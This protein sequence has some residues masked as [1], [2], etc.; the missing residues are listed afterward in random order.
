[1]FTDAD[2]EAVFKVNKMVG[3]FIY[4]NNIYGTKS[5]FCVKPDDVADI[6]TTV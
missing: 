4:K 5:F 1:M 3:C 6:E 2:T